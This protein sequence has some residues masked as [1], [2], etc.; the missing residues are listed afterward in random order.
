[1]ISAGGARRARALPRPAPYP[2]GWRSAAVPPPARHTHT[3]Q[4][5]KTVAW[6][7]SLGRHS[8]A[9]R[10]RGLSQSVHWLWGTISAPRALFPP[11]ESLRP[12]PAHSR[13]LLTF[14]HRPSPRP[15]HRQPATVTFPHS[16]PAM[17]ARATLQR[18]ASIQRAALPRAALPAVPV[19]T[20]PSRRFPRASRRPG[21]PQRRCLQ[22]SSRPPCPWPHP[23]PRPWPPRARPCRCG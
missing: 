19:V 1:M 11:P 20:R 23:W 5:S 9:L 14:P 15:S 6:V 2:L 16:R 12:S 13:A 18:P 17:L 21:A 4:H 3:P 10:V 22:M 8:H 7:H